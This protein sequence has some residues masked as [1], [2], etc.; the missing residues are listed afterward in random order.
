M[1]DFFNPWSAENSEWF[2]ND[3]LASNNSLTPQTSGN[4]TKSTRKVTIKVTSKIVGKYEARSYPDDDIDNNGLQELYEVPVYEII[5]EGTDEKGNAQTFKHQAPRFMPY[6]NDPKAPN[7]SY[8]ARGWVNAGLSSARKVTVN[9]YL[10]NYQ[11]RNMYSPGK[12]AIVVYKAFY[13]HAGPADLT[14]VGFGSAGCIEIIGN[15]NTFKS[16]IQSIS[17]YAGSDAD[18]AIQELV[19]DGNLI[20]IIEKASVPNIKSNF[21]REVN[22]FNP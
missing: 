7:K 11:V 3:V 9:R 15:Y 21:T 2:G 6:W 1:P 22:L 18:D 8:K 4:K 19:K 20:V 10:R 16:N 17:G 12:G 14:N 13:I 5:I